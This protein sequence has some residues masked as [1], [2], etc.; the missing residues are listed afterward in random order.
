MPWLYHKYGGHDLNR[1]GFMMNLVESRNLSR[2]FYTQWHPQVFLTMHEMGRERS[3]G[4]SCRR[5]QIRSTELRPAHL[6]KAALLGS[7]MAMEL[8]R[9]GR[10]GVVS[11]AMFDYYW[12]GYE[13][14]DAPRPQ[15]GVPADRGASAEVA[16]PVVVERDGLARIAAEGLPEY[17]AQTNFPDPW[18]GGKWTLRDIVDYN[19]SAVEGLLTAWRPTGRSS[20]RT[21]TT[22]GGG[23][24]RPGAGVGRSPT[25]SA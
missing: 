11:N 1:D 19:L 25:H 6:E 8:Q 21:S 22:W 9:D 17:R 3:A 2:F 10:S 15:H 14:S 4:I 7:A 23:R 24:W 13:D 20:F 5:M 12:P 18:P 16:T